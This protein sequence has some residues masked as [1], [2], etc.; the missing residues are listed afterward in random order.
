MA[1]AFSVVRRAQE[2]L[3]FQVEILGQLHAAH[4]AVHSSD[5]DVNAIVTLKDVLDFVSPQ[6]FVITGIDM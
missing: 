5:T 1:G 4:Q 2:D 3:G 6:T